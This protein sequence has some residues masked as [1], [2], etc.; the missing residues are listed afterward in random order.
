MRFERPT[1]AQIE[2]F[3]PVKHSLTATLFDVGERA[4]DG[5]RYKTVVRFY[6]RDDKITRY[7]KARNWHAEARHKAS[8]ACHNS[9]GLRRVFHHMQ[10]VWHS[11]R[12]SQMT[13]G[14][15]PLAQKE[16]RDAVARKDQVAVEPASGSFRPMDANEAH[17]ILESADAACYAW[18]FVFPYGDL[19][20]DSPGNTCIRY[21]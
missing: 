18:F 17:E 6:D 12:E 14:V 13:A 1:I 2:F 3:P 19:H 11:A 7:L 16:L 8:V 10:K 20:A 15:L 5:L 21:M 9:H 4:R